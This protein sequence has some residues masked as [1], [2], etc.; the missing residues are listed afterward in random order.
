MPEIHAHKSGEAGIFANAYII[1]TDE[2]L[3][4]VD[5]T[6]TVS[7]AQAFVQKLKALR[8]PLRRC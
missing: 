3:I 6:L 2:S 5:T 8:K 4:A 1:E 7:E